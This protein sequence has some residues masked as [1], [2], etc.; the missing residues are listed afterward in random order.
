MPGASPA[1]APPRAPAPRLKNPSSPWNSANRHG[2]FSGM[3]GAS[4]HLRPINR[5]GHR[6]DCKDET[7]EEAGPPWAH[8]TQA[9]QPP[10]SWGAAWDSSAALETVGPSRARLGVREVLRRCPTETR[11]P[12]T[13]QSSRWAV[14]GSHSLG[15]ASPTAPCTCSTPVTCRPVWSA[16][17]PLGSCVRLAAPPPPCWVPT[18]SP[19]PPGCCTETGCRLQGPAGRACQL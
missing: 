9:C 12:L 6:R 4:L 15:P 8:R 13:A 18:P 11:A 19:G 1:P 14:R 3:R 7:L 17:S 10:A 16:A 5:T 2:L